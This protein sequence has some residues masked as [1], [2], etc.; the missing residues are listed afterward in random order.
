M[1]LVGRITPNEK[2]ALIDSDGGVRDLSCHL[3]ELTPDH[4]SPQLAKT[5]AIDAGY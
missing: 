4:R 2:L 1:K 5:D 3:A